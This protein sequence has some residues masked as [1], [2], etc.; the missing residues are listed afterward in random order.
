M[1][2]VIVMTNLASPWKRLGAALIDGL[3]VVTI[4]VPIMLVTGVL[5]Q[6]FN[7]QPLTLGRQL[8]FL[9]VDGLYF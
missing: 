1:N 8:A 5:Q 9:W 6:A 7:G 3:V 4:L 2:T